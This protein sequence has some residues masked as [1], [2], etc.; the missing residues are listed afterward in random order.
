[1][2]QYADLRADPRVQAL[3]AEETDGLK[4][5]NYELI[6]DVKK[7]RA[8]LRCKE[9]RLAEARKLLSEGDQ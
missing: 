8:K 6:G 9:D 3:I 7:L 1:M 4:R 5:K 2:D